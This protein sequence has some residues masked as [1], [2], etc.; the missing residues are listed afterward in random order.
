MIAWGGRRRCGYRPSEP[1]GR[2][3]SPCMVWA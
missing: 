1:G 2:G 3:T